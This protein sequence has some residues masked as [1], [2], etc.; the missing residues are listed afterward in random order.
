ML[1]GLLAILAAATFGL[2][3]VAIRRGVLTG[4]V[5]QG[6]AITVPIAVP[7][8]F[9]ATYST[10]N[11]FAVSGLSGKTFVLLAFAGITHFIVGRYANY[12]A[13]KAMG[14]NLTGPIISSSLILT[15]ILA[16]VFL[17]EIITSLRMFGIALIVL[18]PIILL[19]SPAALGNSRQS[20]PS[21][22]FKP[23]LVEGYT[24]AILCGV[25]FGT[26][27]ILIRAALLGFASSSVGNGIVGGLIAYLAATALL[28]IYL[29]RPLNLRHARSIDGEAAKWFI[30]T[31]L[32]VCASQMIRFMA[33]AIAPVSVVSPIIQT[34]AIFRTI[35]GWFINRE[36]EVFDTWV[37]LGIFTSIIG[38]MALTLST[39]I[40]LTTLSLPSG[41]VDILSWH[42]P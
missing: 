26:R 13:T 35:F 20:A 21:I 34:S 16:I 3:S 31:G 28:G 7:I 18:G 19:R 33:L 1:G 15:L 4:T 2:N 14:A 17:D 27:P 38:A 23:K 6:L 36:H 41:L 42:W 30:L 40:I 12:R 37:L 10:G 24:F 39:E 32:F 8:F 5:A 9:V 11:L 22:S 25:A 29:M